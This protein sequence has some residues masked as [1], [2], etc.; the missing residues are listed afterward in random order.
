MKYRKAIV[1]RQLG[2]NQMPIKPLDLASFLYYLKPKYETSPEPLLD[3]EFDERRKQYD[4]S[5]IL[6]RLISI[7]KT[8]DLIM[9]VMGEDIYAGNLNFV[10]GVA[11]ESYGVALLSTY[12]L[13]RNASWKLYEER[14]F[15]EAAHEIG[16][17]LGLSHC[18]NHS[19]LMNFSNS[20]D[21]VDTKLPMLCKECMDKLG[22]R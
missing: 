10:F 15:K 18:L 20:I 13:K 12:H 9:Y 8:S 7:P 11:L 2:P 6:T 3:M 21:E 4:A 17:L 16:H 19:C 14:T 1:F 5:R 22:L